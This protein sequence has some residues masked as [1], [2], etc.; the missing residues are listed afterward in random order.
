MFTK[1]IISHKIMRNNQLEEVKW[2]I[3]SFVDI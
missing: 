3:N 2:T 1:L